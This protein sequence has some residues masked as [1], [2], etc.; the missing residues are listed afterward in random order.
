MKKNKGFI[1]ALA[2]IG[3]GAAAYFLFLKKKGDRGNRGGGGED[4]NQ[5]FLPMANKIFDAMDGYGTGNTTIEEELKKLKTKNDWNAL[6]SAFG[7]RTVSSGTWN[8]FQDDFTGT[9]PECLNDELDA[10]ELQRVN[11]ILNRIGVSI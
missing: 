6:V 11:Q 8:V 4:I 1:A 7:T 5:D 2:V 3:L 10:S 9:L